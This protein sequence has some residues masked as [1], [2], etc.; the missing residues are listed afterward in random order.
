MS[1]K[2]DN[3]CGNVLKLAHP[4]QRQGGRSAPIQKKNTQCLEVFI[5]LEVFLL[6][7]C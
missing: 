5:Y 3:V 4:T 7:T 6:M 2:C 1:D